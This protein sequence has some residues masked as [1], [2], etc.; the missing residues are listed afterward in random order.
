MAILDAGFGDCHHPRAVLLRRSLLYQPVMKHP[1][2]GTLG[3]M[4]RIRCRC[5]VAE[6]YHFDTL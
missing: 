3:G 4:L 2:F 6:Y 1:L 5:V